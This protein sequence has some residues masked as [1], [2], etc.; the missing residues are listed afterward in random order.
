MGGGGHC[1]SCIE[2]IEASGEWEIGGI[3]D[4]AFPQGSLILGYEVLGSDDILAELSRR[5]NHA[6]VTVGHLKTPDTRVRIWNALV[7]AGYVLVRIL[8]PSARVSSH[9]VIGEGTIVLHTACVNAG[10]RVGIDCILNT[11]ALIE[12]DAIV[13][14]HVHISTGAIINGDCEVGSETFVGSGAI[15]RNGVRIAPRS[16]IGAGA[17][18]VKD[19]DVSGVYAGNPARLLNG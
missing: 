10:A 19:I 11:G 18:V 1:R 5:C 14:D 3:I 17:V 9:A 8:A 6:L 4:P 13:G 7:A 12:H 2:V 15:L 16:V